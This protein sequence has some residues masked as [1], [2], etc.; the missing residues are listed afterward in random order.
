MS[1]NVKKM[2]LNTQLEQN[3][4]PGRV[5]EFYLSEPEGR[6]ILN[7]V[8]VY[9]DQGELY[10]LGHPPFG[11]FTEFEL[12]DWSLRVSQAMTTKMFSS[13]GSYV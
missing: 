2:S 12:R 1:Q 8:D 5:N 11:V 13:S 10:A 3:K 9:Y 7:V 4:V 6:E